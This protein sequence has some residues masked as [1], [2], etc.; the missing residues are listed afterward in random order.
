M[1]VFAFVRMPIFLKSDDK[2]IVS[3]F[4]YWFALEVVLKIRK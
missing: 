2:R 3:R 4:T 1:G